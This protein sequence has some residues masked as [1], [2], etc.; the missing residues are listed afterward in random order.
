MRETATLVLRHGESS[1]GEVAEEGRGRGCCND[2]GRCW[3][4]VGEQ[5]FLPHSFSCSSLSS[6]SQSPPFIFIYLF[7]IF[8]TFNPECTGRHFLP[9]DWVILSHSAYILVKIPLIALTLSKS[10]EQM[11]EPLETP[12]RRVCRGTAGVKISV[13]TADL[14]SAWQCFPQ[15]SLAL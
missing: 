5:C 10:F 13:Y 4:G 12:N 14:A 9:F 7:I 1:L 2:M 6:S 8:F 11:S 15:L 3:C